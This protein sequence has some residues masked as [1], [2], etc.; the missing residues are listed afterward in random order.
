MNYS[1]NELYIL[2]F[3]M[4]LSPVGFVYSDVEDILEHLDALRQRGCW[5]EVFYDILESNHIKV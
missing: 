3:E 5:E 1:S 2:L 4:C